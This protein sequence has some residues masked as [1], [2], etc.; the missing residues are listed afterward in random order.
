MYT[1]LLPPAINPI[2]VNKYITYHESNY[3]GTF[4]TP[5]LGLRGLC[6]K[7]IVHNDDGAVKETKC[8]TNAVFYVKNSDILAEGVRSLCIILRSVFF[9]H[10]TGLCVFYYAFV[11]PKILYRLLQS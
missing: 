9:W 1:V 8:R 6:T 2:A 4:V 11:C 7:F 10:V 5:A 3:A